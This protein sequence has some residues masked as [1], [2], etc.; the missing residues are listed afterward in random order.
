MSTA[1]SHDIEAPSES[2]PLVARPGESEN[3]PAPLKEM[4]AESV[5]E[6]LVAIAG[7]ASCT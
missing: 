5:K 1:A 6:Q 3:E 7:A 4:K 2:T